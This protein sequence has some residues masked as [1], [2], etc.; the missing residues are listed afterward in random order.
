M[1][2]F[3]TKWVYEGN[4]SPLVLHEFFEILARTGFEVLSLQND[5]HN[6]YLTCKKWGENLDRVADE[7]RARWGDLLYR[8]FR[9]YLWCSAYAFLEGTLDAHRMILSLPADQPGRR[10]RDGSSRKRRLV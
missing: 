5:R 6:Y 10:M 4:T 7:V 1:S 9:L 8:R 3:V 2:A